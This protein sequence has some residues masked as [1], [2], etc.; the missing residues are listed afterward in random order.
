MSH[1]NFVRRGI[2]SPLRIQGKLIPFQELGAD[3]GGLQIE[4]IPENNWVIIQLKVYAAK[5]LGGV[6]EVNDEEFE[7]EKKASSDEQLRLDRLAAQSL[8]Y[9]PAISQARVA[10]TSDPFAP[11]VA[12]TPAAPAPLA[13]PPKPAAV[14]VDPTPD[15]GMI[16][17]AQLSFPK[18][19]TNEA[20]AAMHAGKAEDPAAPPAEAAA[21]SAPT[22]AKLEEL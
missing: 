13:V 10:A 2:S 19:L 21:S 6:V 1:V 5:K 9:N 12:Q 11:A 18:P 8:R 20:Y 3:V 14:R 16:H 15:D 17:G 4:D 7:A 22:T